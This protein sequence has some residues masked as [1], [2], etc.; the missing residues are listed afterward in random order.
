MAIYLVEARPRKDLLD[1]LHKELSS[2]I[3]SKMRPFVQSLQFLVA[4]LNCLL[5]VWRVH[6]CLY[7]LFHFYDDIFYHCCWNKSN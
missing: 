1:N 3:I 6:Y 5:L 4:F 2:G 7:M